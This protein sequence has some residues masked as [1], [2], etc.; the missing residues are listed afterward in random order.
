MINEICIFC[1]YSVDSDAERDY[2]KTM[3]K[4]IYSRM[5]HGAQRDKDGRWYHIFVWQ[6]IRAE[7]QA[8]KD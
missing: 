7:E 4:G 5:S 2:R 3:P 6:C 8:R 1:G